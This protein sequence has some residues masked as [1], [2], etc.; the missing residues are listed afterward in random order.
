MGPEKRTMGSNGT[1]IATEDALS[2]VKGGKGIQPRAASSSGSNA[3]P[4]R[5]KAQVG[6]LWP[7]WTIETPEVTADRRRQIRA[8]RKRWS[9]IGNGVGGNGDFTGKSDN[10][11]S[12]ACSRQLRLSD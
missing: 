6:P 5:F 9:R 8:R 10:W 4:E 2:S 3:E 11:P 1:A 12:S 7:L